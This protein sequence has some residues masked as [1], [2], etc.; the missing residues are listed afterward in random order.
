MPMTEHRAASERTLA[1]DEQALLDAWRARSLATGWSRPDRW[2]APAVVECVRA[3]YGLEGL[4]PAC[5]RL[6]RSRA[7]EGTA[8]D[9]ALA[10]LDAFW[11]EIATVDTPPDVVR[12]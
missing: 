3:S 5:E 11:N 6:A 4:A 9:E 7:A 2:W 12:A 1:R 10:D 8:F